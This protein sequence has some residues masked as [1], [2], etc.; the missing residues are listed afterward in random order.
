MRAMLCFVIS[1]QLL[2]GVAGGQQ[3]QTVPPPPKPAD[4]GAP[5]DVTMNFI[6]TKLGEIGKVNYA[7]YVHDN[8]DNTD[9]VEQRSIEATDIVADSA[10]CRLTFH[11]TEDGGLFREAVKGQAPTTY[12]VKFATTQ[13]D[14]TVAVTRAWAPRAA[15]RFYE[16]VRDHFYD[17][18]SFFRV[19]PDFVVQFGISAYP[20]A[21]AT[22]SK[23]NIVDDPVTQTNLR[24]SLSFA[25]AGPNTRTTQV[26]INLGNN[27]RLDSMGFAPF[28][29]VTSGM[30]VINHFNAD[31]ADQPTGHQDDIT[32]QGKAFLDKNFPKLDSIKTAAI[33]ADLSST[34]ITISLR[35]VLNLTIRPA[36][37][38]QKKTDAD[39]GH[40]T[41]T[42]R[43]E[44]PVWILEVR[45]EGNVR[46]YL[47]FNDEDM[48]DHLAKAM[49]HAVELCG[50]GSK[51]PF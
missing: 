8:A 35:Q 48:A 37:E 19:I 11:L 39:A 23:A 46:N 7:R 4:S 17:N 30:D 14:F 22:W 9:W 27:A 25:S 51:D 31:Y 16:L 28:G 32:N 6:R 41:Y 10:G 40:P 3:K 26:F 18:A 1:F 29:E 13:G 2:A 45:S 38:S 47:Y 15:D 42:S 34:L 5:L 49:V 20:A 33:V 50:G 44:P 43:F 36:E 24:G 21:S 12:R